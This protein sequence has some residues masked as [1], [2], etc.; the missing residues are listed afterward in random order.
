MRNPKADMLL[1]L[2]SSHSTVDVWARTDDEGLV[3]LPQGVGDKGFV[4]LQLGLALP[5][6]IR[7]LHIGDGGFVATLSFSRKPFHVIVL[8]DAVFM[9]STSDGGFATYDL[10]Y[11]KRLSAQPEATPS[12]I[13]VNKKTP[14]GWGVIDG[15]KATP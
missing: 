7:D 4:R 13:R 5:I 9:F 1:E 11:V 8:W 2:L 10:E 14:P 15:G 3:T 6:P 12:I